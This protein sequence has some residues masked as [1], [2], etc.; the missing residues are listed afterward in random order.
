[1]TATAKTQLG[2]ID[3][4]RPPRDAVHIASL[5]TPE[6]TPRSTE[7]DELF[8]VGGLLV[9]RNERRLQS[10][11]VHAAYQFEMPLA[12]VRWV[13]DAIEQQFERKPSEGGAPRNRFHVDGSIEGESL[14]VR[15]GVS[16]GGEGVGGYTIY[17]FS[18]ASYILPEATQQMSFAIDDWRDT[19]RDLFHDIAQRYERGEFG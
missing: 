15:Y 16:V 8:A 18:R 9:E 19:I 2:L 6:P 10:G 12:A 14:E 5:P 4:A 17:N 3:L 1:M 13:I 7:V 11:K